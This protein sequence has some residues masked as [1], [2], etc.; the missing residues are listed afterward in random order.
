MNDRFGSTARDFAAGIVT[1]EGGT[2]EDVRELSYGPDLDRIVS[3][4]R[5]EFDWNTVPGMGARVRDWYAEQFPDDPLGGMIASDVTFAQTVES[6]HGGDVYDRLGVG[7][8]VVREL[9]NIVRLETVLGDRI[10]YDAYH[11]INST[12]EDLGEWLEQGLLVRE[13]SDGARRTAGSGGV[14]LNWIR[15]RLDEWIRTAP[16]DADAR[17]TWTAGLAD[18]SER[19]VMRV[20]AEDELAQVVEDHYWNFPGG[21]NSCMEFYSRPDFISESYV[22]WK[23]G[24]LSEG[25]L[26]RTDRADTDPLGDPR[27][28]GATTPTR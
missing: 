4:H 27:A 10:G 22:E 24:L 9:D 11:R 1:R 13:A 14:P 21:R 20:W 17:Y 26:E 6:L 3:D 15:G 23:A 16:I 12:M 7:E 19:D 5:A 8:S 25:D 18:Q 28:F 2:T